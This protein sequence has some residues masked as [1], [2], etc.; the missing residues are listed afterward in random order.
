MIKEILPVE[1]HEV[2]DILARELGRLRSFLDEFRSLKDV[3]NL[4]LISGDLRNIVDLI[5][6]SHSPAWR[7]RGIATEQ[8]ISGGLSLDCDAHKLHQVILNICKN[9]VESM[10]DG[11]T[12]SLRGYRSDDDVILEVSDTGAGIPEGIDI[13]KLFVS[14][15][16]QGAGLGLYI[17]QQI[18]AAHH[19]TISYSTEL[20]KGTTIRILLPRCQNLSA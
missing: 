5:V 19:G 1:H 10:P 8:L 20:G 12:L 16:P 9:S 13:F 6:K 11:G 18:V 17:V 2:C 14:T 4:K 15:K 7:E 3:T